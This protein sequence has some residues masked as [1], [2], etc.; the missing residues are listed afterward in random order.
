MLLE[1]QATL[2]APDVASCPTALQDLAWLSPSVFYFSSCW[3][4]C[5]R[6]LSDTRLVGGSPRKSGRGAQTQHLFP[7]RPGICGISLQ[8]AVNH[9]ARHF[10]QYV[11]EIEFGDAVALKVR[12]RIQ[13]INRIG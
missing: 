5:R 3:S 1:S 9:H 2:S 8:S 13:E 12:R 11:F 7:S 6:C 4:S 10:V